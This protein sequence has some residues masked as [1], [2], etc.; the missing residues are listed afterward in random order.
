MLLILSIFGGCHGST[1]GGIKMIRI[2]FLSK[3]YN[4]EIKVL[5]HPQLISPLKYNNKPIDNSIIM[6][7]FAFTTAFMT[8]YLFLMFL[9]A[10]SGNDLTS[11]LA[12]VTGTLT[13]SGISL[14][15][16]AISYEHINPFTKFIS[17]LSMLAGRLEIFSLFIICSIPFWEN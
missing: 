10:L 17:I 8:L 9:L 2:L 12:I 7:L 13:N 5:L 1:S 3:L 6:S 15:S 11:S 14:G 16:V 4:R